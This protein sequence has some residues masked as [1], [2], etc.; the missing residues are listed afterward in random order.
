LRELPTTAKKVGLL[1]VASTVFLAERCSALQKMPQSQL[2]GN[3][4][5]KLTFTEVVL[6]VEAGA[7]IDACA[8]ITLNGV[9]LGEPEDMVNPEM[10][11]GYG[12]TF[13]EVL[14]MDFDT[15]EITGSSVQVPM[16]EA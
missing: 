16:G 1:H 2:L 9:F 4:M 5:T 14:Q 10:G 8:G 11:Q 7:T 15:G 3:E 6:A 12:P 13:R